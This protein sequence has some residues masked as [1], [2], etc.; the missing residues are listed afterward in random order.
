MG[1]KHK[2]FA[3]MITKRNYI[4]GDSPTNQA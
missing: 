1:K 3:K 4:R 2:T